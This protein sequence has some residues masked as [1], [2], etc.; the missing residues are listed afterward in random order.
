MPGHTAEQFFGVFEQAL[1]IA[2]IPE[3]GIGG[4]ERGIVMEQFHGALLR[5][6]AA[7][8]GHPHGNILPTVIA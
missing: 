8:Q 7:V 1:D 3:I 2:Q 5:A 6:M 4:E